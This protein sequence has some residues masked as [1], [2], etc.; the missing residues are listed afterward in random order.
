MNVRKYANFTKAYKGGIDNWMLNW[1]QSWAGLLDGIIGVVTL[2][3][4]SSGFEMNVCSY[5]T[6][7]CIRKNKT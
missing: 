2:G 6:I 1:I 7:Y 5:R 3:L 4:I